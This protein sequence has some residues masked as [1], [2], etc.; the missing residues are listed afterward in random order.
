MPGV[1][2]RE[3][4]DT[5]TKLTRIYIEVSKGGLTA[6]ALVGEIETHIE[7]LMDTEERLK[8]EPVVNAGDAE[9]DEFNFR[10]MQVSEQGGK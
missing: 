1:N 6:N 10:N 2:P 8:D 4:G 9:P 7:G 5:M 3:R